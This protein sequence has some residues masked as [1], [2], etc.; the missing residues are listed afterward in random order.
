MIELRTYQQNGNDQVARLA[1]AGVRRIVYQAATGSGKTITFASL[2]QRF[3]NSMRRRIVIAVHRQELLWQTAKALK[4][5]ANIDAGFLIAEYK[6]VCQET[7]PGSG[8][9]IPHSAAKVVIC[10]V[11]TLNNRM[12]K[13]EQILGDVGLLIVDECHTGNFNKIYKHFPNSLIV[14]FTATP[15][16]AQKKIPL[17]THFD[18]IVAPASI[19]YLIDQGYLAKNITISVKNGVNRKKLKIR[20]GE[21]DERIMASIYSEGKHVKNTVKAYTQYCMGEKTVIFNCNIAHSKLVTEAFIEAGYNCRH[22]DG[23]ASTE[24][25]RT[26]LKWLKETPDAILSSVNLVTTGFDEPTVLNIIVNRAT[27]SLT[28]WLQMCGRGSRSIPGVKDHFKIIDLGSNV[29]THMD[30]NYPHDW[31]DLFHNPERTKNGT[32]AAPTKL[33]GGCE[34]MIHLSTR[35]CPFC[36]Y[37]NAKEIKYDI[38]DLELEVITKGVDIEKIIERNKEY[39][40]Y[41]ALHHAKGTLV[42]KFKETYK[43]NIVPQDIRMMLNER[44]QLLV[45]AW[46]A[47]NQ[48]KYDGWHKDITKKWLLDELDKVYGK[49]GERIETTT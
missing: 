48:K 16:S 20:G 32:G 39:S 37:D 9:Y 41:R 15:L 25:R 45:K 36:G 26:T 18:E 12:K 33:C 19:Q 40:P 1:K 34:A 43:G 38:R 31:R 24:E 7:A 3:W 2:S 46:C 11:E 5:V 47:Q 44:F 49:V 22:L 42:R 14:G 28:L 6:T 8:I 30:W 35:I 17:K 21:F 10:M 4:T 27:M 13:Y 29:A 23:N